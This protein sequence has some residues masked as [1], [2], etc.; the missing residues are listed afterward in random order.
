MKALN[1]AKERG[2][3]PATVIDVGAAEGNWTLAPMNG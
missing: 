1:N 3:I 2:I